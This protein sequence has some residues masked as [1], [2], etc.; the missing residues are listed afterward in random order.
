MLRAEFPGA[1]LARLSYY[2]ESIELHSQKVALSGLITKHSNL[3]WGENV[4]QMDVP[5]VHSK[6]FTFIR[7]P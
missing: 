7:R 6:I 2:G 3:T 1:I 5:G 4:Q